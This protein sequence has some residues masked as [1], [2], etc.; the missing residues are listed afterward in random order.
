MLDPG[1]CDLTFCIILYFLVIVLLAFLAAFFSVSFP[2]KGSGKP[3]AMK[4]KTI[5]NDSD[6]NHHDDANNNHGSAEIGNVD[7]E[8]SSHGPND[9]RNG[10]LSNTTPVVPTRDMD[11][12]SVAA[13]QPNDSREARYH[14]RVFPMRRRRG[15][16]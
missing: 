5:V 13:T 12:A 11:T 14:V 2:T 16:P 7:V 8:D 9:I 6:D 4:E 15:K 1:Y 10:V 3:R